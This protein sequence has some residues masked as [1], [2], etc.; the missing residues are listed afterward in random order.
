MF[1]FC[2]GKVVRYPVRP[3]NEQKVDMLTATALLVKAVRID[4]P[5]WEQILI[6]RTDDGITFRVIR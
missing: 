5:D 1:G 2:S 3:R 4:H 6:E